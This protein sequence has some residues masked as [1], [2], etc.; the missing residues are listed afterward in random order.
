MV[1]L[2]Q[3]SFKDFLC[4]VYLPHSVGIILSYFSILFSIVL[5]CL[6]LSI[7]LLLQG[8]FNTVSTC[9]VVNIFL[10]FAHQGTLHKF[11]KA[12]AIEVLTAIEINFSQF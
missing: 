6:P 9:M 5:T 1:P 3:H 2:E 8:S 4:I 11:S 7:A 10:K 12:Q